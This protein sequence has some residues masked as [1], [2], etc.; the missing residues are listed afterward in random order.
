MGSSSSST[1][2]SAERAAVR[3]RPG[4]LCARDV[5][6][7]GTAIECSAAAR[8][9]PAPD[10]TGVVTLLHQADWTRLSTRRA[11]RVEVVIDRELG[12]LLRCK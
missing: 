11:F 5:T 6:A 1:A 4:A 3:P 10:L 9:P 12:T 7:M 8:S 2:T